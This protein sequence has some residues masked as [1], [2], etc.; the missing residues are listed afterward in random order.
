[1]R[2][3]WMELSTGL[4]AGSGPDGAYQINWA[5]SAGEKVPGSEGRHITERGKANRHSRAED[6]GKTG[7]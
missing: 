5:N 6:P 3:T 7:T 4:L 1:M 2:E